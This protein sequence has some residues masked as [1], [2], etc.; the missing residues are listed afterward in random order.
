MPGRWSAYL[1]PHFAIMLVLGLIAFPIAGVVGAA[2]FRSDVLDF[3]E[4]PATSKQVARFEDDA[5]ALAEVLDASRGVPK[6]LRKSDKIRTA[7]FMPRPD[8]Q[9]AAPFGPINKIEP[10]S[11]FPGRGFPGGWLASLSPK[12]DCLEDINRFMAVQGYTKSRL[13]LA[14]EQRAAWKAVE[15]ANEDA[16]GKLRAVCQALPREAAAAPGIV[17]RL[18]FAE[19]QLAARLELLHALK[20]PMRELLE[21]SSVDQRASLDSL[22]L[23]SPPF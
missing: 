9:D 3:H 18:E 11:P 15:D 1:Y 5:P 6:P 16:A 7:L 10:S 22:A 23:F 14:E 8:L 2:S 20:V 21:K 19:R 12:D 4:R 13:Q 17:E